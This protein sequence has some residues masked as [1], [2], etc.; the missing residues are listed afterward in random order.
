MILEG[1]GAPSTLL[2]SGIRPLTRPTQSAYLPR[3]GRHDNRLSMKMRRRKSQK[4]LKARLKRK[5]SEKR[6]A[7]TPAAGATKTRAK[8]PREAAPKE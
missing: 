7:K 2:P 1:R 4:K 3:M 6:V 8:K 5:S